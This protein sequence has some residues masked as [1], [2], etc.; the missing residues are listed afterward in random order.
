MLKNVLNKNTQRVVIIAMIVSALVYI[1]MNTFAPKVSFAHCNKSHRSAY[2][3][4]PR[5]ITRR[6]SAYVLKPQLSRPL[7]RR[8][9]WPEQPSL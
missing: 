6:K 2:G 1:L 4:K 8:V 5:A 9:R 7:A 3:L